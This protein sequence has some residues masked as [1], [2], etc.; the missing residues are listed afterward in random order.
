M[1]TTVS[2]RL[3]E[4][5]YLKVLEI[6]PGSRIT[7]PR[8]RVEYVIANRLPVVRWLAVEEALI[9]GINLGFEH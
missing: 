6:D 2:V 1:K 3:E 7:S 9:L 4:A 5:V 8:V